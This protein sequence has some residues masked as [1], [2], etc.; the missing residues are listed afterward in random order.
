MQKVAKEDCNILFPRSVFLIISSKKL[1]KLSATKIFNILR[2]KLS[3]R[4]PAKAVSSAGMHALYRPA[5]LH[6]PLD[7]ALIFH[8]TATASNK[9]HQTEMAI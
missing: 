3:K 9:P 1:H 6:A 4:I 2:T 5:K 7:H 8:M